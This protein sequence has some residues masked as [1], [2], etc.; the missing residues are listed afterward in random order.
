MPLKLDTKIIPY[1][2]D[3][4]GDFD[5]DDLVKHEKLIELQI[6]ETKSRSHRRLAAAAFIAVVLIIAVLMTPYVPIDR[7]VAITGIVT[8]VILAFVGM[9]SAYFGAD[10]YITNKLN[11]KR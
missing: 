1:D 8:T 2:I 7:V 10:A 6:R 5:P 9:I 11:Q 3:H 4:D